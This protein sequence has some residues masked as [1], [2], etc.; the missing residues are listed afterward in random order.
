MARN[1]HPESGVVYCDCWKIPGGGVEQ[2]ETKLETLVREV[3][4][5]TGI[6]ITSF[7]FELVDDLMTGE[8]EKVLRDTGEK[9]LAKMQFYTYKVILDKP[10]AEIPITL[11]AHEFDEY[12]W[13]E[14]SE[15]KSIKLSPPS[16]ELFTKLGFLVSDRIVNAEI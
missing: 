6:D 3:K 10:S 12:K 13:F 9:V 16:I 5:E 1:T 15:L 11:D 2:G 8:A 7:Q 4:E 14:L